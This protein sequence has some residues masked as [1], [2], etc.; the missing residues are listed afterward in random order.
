MAQKPTANIIT[1]FGAGGDLTWRKLIPALFDLYAADHLPEQ[2]SI[3]GVDI[4]DFDDATFRKHAEDGVSKFARYRQEVKGKWAAFAE[5]LSY[6]Q[7]DFGKEETYRGLGERLRE[8]DQA[9][10][11][12]ADYIFYLATAPTFVELIAENLYAAE[13][14]NDHVRSRVVVEKPFGHDLESAR[15]LNQQLLRICPEEQ[16]YRIDHYLG[17]ETVQNILAFRFANALYE[18]IWNR[19]YIDH[20]QITVAESVGVGHRGGYY[21]HAGALRDMV[22]NHLMQIMCLIAMEPP[23]SFGADEI[24]SRKVDV[25]RAVRPMRLEDVDDFA[26]RGQ[27]AEGWIEGEHVEAYREEPDVAQG[28]KTETFAALK[29]YVDNWRWRGVPFYLRS[30][31]HLSERVSEAV[32]RFKPV[33]H[34]AFPETLSSHWQP[35]DLLM[36]IQPNEGIALKMQAKVPGLGMQLGEVDMAFSYKDAFQTAS[37]EAYETLLLDAMRGDATLFMRSDQV[38]KAWEIVMP[39]LEYWGINRDIPQYDAGTWGPES[40]TEL[41]ARDGRSWVRPQK[42]SEG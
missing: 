23:V 1:I 35:N 5:R 31:K 12:M 36:F 9:W 6:I 4:K 25:L 37:P 16:I 26:A 19:N 17:K 29:L 22:Q 18:P 11:V 38:E 3:I 13:L 10:D 34:Q 15:A 32:I 14:L 41:I 7:G 2:M 33:P 20:V 27:Y 24:R 42:I 8:R 39:V 30:G 40:A 21:D 28:S